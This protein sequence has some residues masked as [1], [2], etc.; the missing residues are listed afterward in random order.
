[1][2]EPS[3]KSCLIGKKSDFVAR[4]KRLIMLAERQHLAVALTQ[5]M[6]LG[7]GKAS[8]HSRV[9]T[10]RLFRVHHGV[11]A[12]GTRQLP[13]HGHWMAAVLALGPGAALS[14]RS[15][16]ALWGLKQTSQTYIEVIAPVGGGRSRSGIRVHR[17]SWLAPQDITEVDGIPC[18]S[19]ARTILDV[20]S[21]LDV[22]RSRRVVEQAEILRIFDRRALD[23]VIGR[24]P[25]TV[26]SRSLRAVLAE[27]D[28]DP[29]R[30]K[31]TLEE[32]VLDLCARCRIRR[33]E[34]N[35]HIE[36]H[37]EWFEVDFLW[38]DERLIL[39]ADSREFH[40]SGAAF[41]RDRRRDQRLALAGFQTIRCTS[42]QVD[43]ATELGTTISSLLTLRAA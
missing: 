7:F 30:T 25:R 18:T 13:R 41:E 20:C 31:S 5:L 17:S 23:D 1:V 6:L 40:D 28:P 43:E 11:Y 3:R 22:A 24:A 14:H 16:A 32:R 4:E 33:P 42:T 29:P 26:S 37:G 38:R 10:G 21:G 19:L 39:E 34:V 8:I 9:A 2:A 27:L 36:V 35:T 12:V 15:A